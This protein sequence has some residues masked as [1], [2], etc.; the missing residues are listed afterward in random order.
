MPHRCSID[1][2]PSLLSLPKQLQAIEFGN[3]VEAS[4]NQIGS[5]C[6]GLGCFANEV[7]I[8]SGLKLDVSQSVL[9]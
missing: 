2:E 3:I 8:L 6:Y 4:F 5:F 9:D 7:I 1:T